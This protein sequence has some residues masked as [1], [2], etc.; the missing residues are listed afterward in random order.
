MP[1]G[2]ARGVVDLAVCAVYGGNSGRP[3]RNHWE[4]GMGRL[5]FGFQFGAPTPGPGASGVTDMHDDVG[6]FGW[7]ALLL[8][9][10]V[11]WNLG[12]ISRWWLDAQQGTI[13]ETPRVISRFIEN[14]WP[15]R[16][17]AVFL[18][19]GACA[20]LLADLL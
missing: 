6:P 2:V 17:L 7:V 18:A 3:Q 13:M 14:P 9:A 16:V 10:V 4:A 12:R 15:G 8:V 19:I 11:A 5:G 1:I 20:S